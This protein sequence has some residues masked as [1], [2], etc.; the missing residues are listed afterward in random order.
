MHV[1][2]NFSED[3]T[4]LPSSVSHVT[5]HDFIVEEYI[6]GTNSVVGMTI[7]TNCNKPLALKSSIVDS[8]TGN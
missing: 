5:C 2:H 6:V 1:K 3:Y 7:P 4:L 8:Y